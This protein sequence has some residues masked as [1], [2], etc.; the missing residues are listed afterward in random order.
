MKATLS[1]DL[2]DLDQRQE[3]LRCIKSLDLSLCVWDIIQHLRTKLKH[4]DLSEHDYSIYENV[5]ESFFRIL[6]ENQINI[7]E[8]IN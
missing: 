4:G 5:Q 3:H 8:L 2:T 7:E 1:F 6:E